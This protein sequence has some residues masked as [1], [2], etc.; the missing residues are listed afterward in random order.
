MAKKKP[1]KLHPLDVR[2]LIK[3]GKIV[4]ARIEENAFAIDRDIFDVLIPR[5]NLTPV[6]QAVYLQLYRH[7]YGRGLNCAQLSNS[8]I[9]RLCNLSHSTVRT[10]LRKLME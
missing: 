1:V 2:Q 7:A 10:T 6:E 4:G 5:I 3:D 8:E 9:Q